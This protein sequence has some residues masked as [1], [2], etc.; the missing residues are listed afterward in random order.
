MTTCNNALLKEIADNFEWDP[1]QVDSEG[2]PLF[3]QKGDIN[4]TKILHAFKRHFIEAG[5]EETIKA[6]F[7]NGEETLYQGLKSIPMGNL[8][9]YAYGTLDLDTI[10][11]KVKEEGIKP[12]GMY[13]V[14]P[15][16]A[17]EFIN[18]SRDV[19]SYIYD[20]RSSSFFTRPSSEVSFELPTVGK[21]A[22][23]NTLLESTTLPSL[24]DLVNLAKGSGDQIKAAQDEA[25]ASSK[26]RKRVE[27]DMKELQDI[28][29]DLQAKALAAST[30]SYE[31]EESHDGTI[32][33]GKTVNK[34]IKDIFPEVEFETNFEVPTWEWDGVHPEV[35]KADP[36]YIFRAKELTRVLYA[37]LT[38]QR[39]YLQGHTGSGKTTL[40]EQVAARMGWPFIRVNF[41]SEITR[42]DLIGRDT[43]TTDPTTG[44]V[45]SEFVDGILPSAMSA[46]CIFCADEIDFVRPDVAYV[47]Q[48]ALEGNGLRIT[49]DGGRHVKPN[50]MFRMFATGNTVGQGDEEGM[51]QGARPQSL[52]LLDRF[53]IWV[54]VDYLNTEQRD[55]LVKRHYPTLSEADRTKLS[56][57]V[58]EHL[59][60]FKNGDVLQPISPRGMLAI[61][62][63][64]SVFGNVKEALS[65]TVLDRASKDDRATLAGVV[66]RVA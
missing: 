33:S 46:P 37:V 65:M 40:I 49:E 54:N 30:A 34:N 59:E 61:A 10:L 12:S 6:S 58:V 18:N 17:Q 19:C 9:Q 60:A 36:H 4:A 27:K 57:Y 1:N 26:K 25:R 55:Q 7:Q 52:A 38:N 66:D 21:R 63:A 48:A 15:E 35:P 24:E 16:D 62:A 41:D 50:P 39:A 28:M 13:G 32:P 43:L 3:E 14:I 2:K 5:L 31:T 42:M 56:K 11:E 53:T 29:T 22:A 45:K 23:I 8:F 51:Y 64:T 47:M 44:T 20:I